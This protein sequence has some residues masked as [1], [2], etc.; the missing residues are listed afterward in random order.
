[1]TSKMIPILR[2]CTSLASVL[3]VALAAVSVGA[4][5]VQGTLIGEKSHH[6]IANAHVTLVDDSGHVAAAATT[7]SASGTF[8]LT[9]LGK[10]RY[11]VRVLVGH[12]GVTNTPLF[13]LD[14]D[15]T[16]ERT[17][18][19]PDWSD[20]YL[21]AFLPDD[22]TTPARLERRQ[23]PRYPDAAFTHQRAGVAVLRFVVG[24][25]GK[26]D[27][28]TLAVVSSDDPLFAQSVANFAVSAHFTPAAI[29]STPVAQVYELPVDF[30]FDGDPVRITGKQGIIVRALARRRSP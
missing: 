19:A 17:I 9:A 27:P 12:G 21:N 23:A 28:S 30:G 4:Q 26:V 2:A 29:G 25:D 6:P 24:A 15:Q 13:Q 22:V 1:M 5:T 18:V 7:D 3:T 11:S 10:G 8:Y 14:S 20:A 16:V